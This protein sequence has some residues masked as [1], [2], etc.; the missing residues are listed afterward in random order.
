MNLAGL[1]TLIYLRKSR[2]DLESEARGEGDTLARHRTQLLDYAQKIGVVVGAIYE[3]VVSGDTIAARPQMQRLLSEV[4]SGAWDAVL[5][6]EIER[7]ARGDSIDQG[8]VARAFRYSET[9][10]IT[11]VKVYDPTNEFDE[12]FLEFG[13][14][15]SRREYKTIRRR[16]NAGVQASRREGKFT[17]SVAPYGYLREKLKGEKGYT[18]V[19]DPETAPIVK[20]IYT[21][22]LRDKMHPYTIMKRLNE[23]QIPSVAGPSWYRRTI[24]NI[25]SNP[26][27]AG[28]TTAS[29]RPVKMVVVDGELKKTRPRSKDVTLYEG[30]HEPLIP[31]EDWE[32]VQKR[33]SENQAPPVPRG[34]GQT[35]AFCGLIYCSHCGSRMQRNYTHHGYTYIYC[36]NR[37]YTGCPTI[38]ASYTLIES[39]VCKT[40]KNWALGL[41]LNLDNVPTDTTVYERSLIDLNKKREEL[42]AREARAFELV[43]TGVYTPEVFVQRKTALEQEQTEIENKIINLNDAVL[44]LK[45]NERVC[46]EFIP[47][48]QSV[49]DVYASS[50][51]HERNELLKTVISRIEYKKT[52]R[53]LPNSPGDLELHIFPR[54]PFNPL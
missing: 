1:N 11:P 29:R 38:S 24:V 4:E 5:V 47:R 26:H 20:D 40:L 44:K 19:P 51:P 27:Y 39:I 9:K 7:L 18:L 52:K 46:K 34:K 35:N 28:Y 32:T 10:I 41:D 37:H 15:M 14:F 36:M 21:W 45:Q 42:A 49:L 50:N 13:L 6:M 23:M 30:R 2:A 54:L 16:L 33:L 31:R 43:E 3:E 22:F 48:V 25:L 12:E 53:V 17:G 8:V